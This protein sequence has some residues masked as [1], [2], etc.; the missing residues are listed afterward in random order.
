MLAFEHFQWP[1]RACELLLLFN[2]L[3]HLYPLQLKLLLTQRVTPQHL[4]RRP[5]LLQLPLV[6]QVPRRL[7]HKEQPHGQDNRHN[8]LNPQ[9]NL[10]RCLVQHLGRDIC[11]GRAHDAPDGYPLREQRNQDGTQMGRGRLGAVDVGESDEKAVADAEDQAAEVHD[12][13]VSG[14]YLDGRAD[15]RE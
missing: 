4:K 1:N 15:G 14:T 10:I 8:K 12:S 11:H 5:S 7:G 6:H 9:G 2:S 13:P 3:D